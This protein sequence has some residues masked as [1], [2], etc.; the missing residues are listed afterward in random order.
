MIAGRR[1]HPGVMVLGLIII[2]LSLIYFAKSREQTV[3]PRTT[4]LHAQ[5]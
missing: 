2:V 3:P 4:P 1:G 5:H